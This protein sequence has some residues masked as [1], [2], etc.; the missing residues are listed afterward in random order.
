ML[1]SET[2]SPEDWT[3]RLDPARQSGELSPA[4]QKL[5]SRESV[6]G[7]TRRCLELL[8]HDDSEVRLWAGEVLESIVQPEASEAETLTQWLTELLERQSAGVKEPD[9][10][11]LADQLYWTATMIGRIG[12]EATAADASL[13]RLE[14]LGEDPHATAYHAAAA[15]AGRARNSLSG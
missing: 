6:Q 13:A 11:L 10:T 8:D 1:N 12:A 3:D 9:A 2:S 7:V 15:R 5:A 14:K 4:L